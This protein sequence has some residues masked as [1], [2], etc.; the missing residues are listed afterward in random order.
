MFIYLLI[1]HSETDSDEDIE[2]EDVHK[3]RQIAHAVGLGQP[4]MV[5]IRG[6]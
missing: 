1:Y 2:D 5:E 3:L 4:I 6:Q